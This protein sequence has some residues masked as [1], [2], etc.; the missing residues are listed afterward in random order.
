MIFQ[1]LSHTKSIQ[2]NYV[3]CIARLIENFAACLFGF[4]MM[5]M[6]NSNLLC[7]FAV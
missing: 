4:E 5:T 3:G 1:N 2:V 6:I 7:K